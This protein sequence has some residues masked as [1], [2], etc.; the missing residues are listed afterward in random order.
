VEV[1]VMGGE[2]RGEQRGLERADGPAA[3]RR[4]VSVLGYSGVFQGLPGGKTRIRGR[5]LVE[6]AAS[7][8]NEGMERRRWDERRE[9]VD[10]ALA[11][12]NA[13]SVRAISWYSGSYGPEWARY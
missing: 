2:Q 7:R 1:D 8:G 3:I 6:E 5:R 11:T 12:R 10:M 13:V 4:D 9:A